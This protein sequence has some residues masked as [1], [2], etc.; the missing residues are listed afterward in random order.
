[1]PS[2]DFQQL[3]HHDFET[4]VRDLLQA[5]WY[6]RFE[7]FKPGKDGGIDIRFLLGGSKSI[8]QCKHFVRTGLPGLLREMAKEVAN[9][10][11]LNADRYVLVTSVPLSP[12]NKDKIVEIV[13]A[14]H[15]QLPDILGQ[16]DL[17]NLLGRHPEIEQQHYKL[18]LSSRAVLDRVLHNASVTQSEF[19]VQQ[20]YDQIRRYIPSDAY[21]T[22]R[23]MLC[24]NRVVI[25]AG[26]PGV[27]KTTLA[28]MLLY[29]HLEAGYQAILIQRDV[30]EG[31]D[32]FQPGLPQIFYFDDFMGATYLGDP[33]SAFHRN[34]DRA[35]LDFLAMIRASSD[36]RLV[37]TTR[38][39]ILT[40][41]L[42]R[43]ERMRHSSLLD[44]RLVLQMSNYSG[45]QRAQIL[46]NHLYFSDLPPEYQDEL[47]RGDFY[48]EIIR[49]EKFNP[50][51]VDWLSSY[52]R[53]RN[54]TVSGYRAF[55]QNLL[56]DPSEIWRHA[57][58]WEISDA[59]RS[60]LLALFSLA[61]KAGDGLQ[62]AFAA[63]HRARA[64]RYNF[65]ARPDDYRNALRE[66]AGSFVKPSSNHAVEVLDP[67]VLDLLNSV[68]SEAPDNAVDL[69]LGSVCFHQIDRIWQFAKTKGGDALMA[70]LAQEAQP[71]AQNLRPLLLK[72]R[73]YELDDGTVSYHGETFERRLAALIRFA[74]WLRHRCFLELVEE[75]TSRLF[76][77]WETDDASINDGVDLLRTLDCVAWP[78]LQK[79]SDI[80]DFIRERLVEEAV[81]GC[82]ADELREL[83]CVIDLAT[84]SDGHLHCSLRG[85]FKEYKRSQFRHDLSGCRSSE[86]FE[87]FIED[88][89]LFSES[90]GVDTA[91]MI[92]DTEERMIE[93][94]AEQEARDSYNEDEYKERWRA[95]RSTEASIKDMFQSLATD[96]S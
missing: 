83:T 58:R 77:E 2:Y 92:S 71:L 43:S 34:G 75:T 72:D 27:G 14:E 25:L 56:R 89:K 9:V 80:C 64:R 60:L 37:L 10:R 61:G 3:S 46:Y 88:L 39:H 70:R 38:E 24:E 91:E 8:F 17:N 30:Q 47:L 29:E 93:F 54:V 49:H 55:V 51:L 68:V 16:D 23:H 36:A 42:E 85:A 95:D 32:R 20:V 62:P 69:F 53:V 40:Q 45:G 41:A 84:D 52:S 79:E 48:F 7:C 96:R 94:Q 86:Q 12:S 35:I 18:W 82:R 74:D 50:R 26:P 57:Y 44:H 1:M 65:E 31:F 21:P 90:L 6:C 28:N 19:K 76:K 15:I 33:S 81:S 87:E 5:E 4:M 73:R 13:G 63:L 67:S 66:L 78:P 22:A 59:A 11:E